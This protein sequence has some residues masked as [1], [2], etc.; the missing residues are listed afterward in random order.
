MNSIVF[1][2]QLD[3]V[4]ERPISD[5]IILGSELFNTIKKRKKREKEHW[6]LEDRHGQGL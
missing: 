6:S 2:F 4:K 3:F 5:N 1:H